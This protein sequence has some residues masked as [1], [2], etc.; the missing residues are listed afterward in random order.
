[1]RNEEKSIY[2][3]GVWSKGWRCQPTTPRLDWVTFSVNIA[4]DLVLEK[5]QKRIFSEAGFG[6]FE[7]VFGDMTCCLGIFIDILVFLFISLIFVSNRRT[8]YYLCSLFVDLSTLYFSCFFVLIRLITIHFFF[9]IQRFFSPPYLLDPTSPS[10]SANINNIHVVF[11]VFYPTCQHNQRIVPL[12]TH[13]HT[14]KK[15]TYILYI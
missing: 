3:L 13:T 12:S 15:K 7:E 9:S 8:S 5:D 6:K 14:Q 11:M 10:T 1:M 2:L 4:C